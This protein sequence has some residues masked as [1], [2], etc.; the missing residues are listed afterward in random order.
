M[1]RSTMLAASLRRRCIAR[2]FSKGPIRRRKPD[3]ESALL[4]S[5]VLQ[6][7]AWP[8]EDNTAQGWMIEPFNPSSDHIKR[9]SMSPWVPCP[10]PVAR[11]MLELAKA[12]PDDIHVDLGSGDGRVNFQAMDAPFGVKRSIGID[13]DPEI[14]QKARDRL[15]KRFPVPDM[16]FYIADLKDFKNIAWDH[17]KDATIITMYFVE[18]A[19]E[20]IRPT[21]ERVLK[22]RM[23]TVVTCGYP[24]TKWDPSH[25][26]Y[27]LG[28]PVHVYKIGYPKE[29]VDLSPFKGMSEA[30]VEKIM[31]DHRKS[32]EE[33]RLIHKEE[34]DLMPAQNPN[35]N[36]EMQPEFP[37]KNYEEFMQE[38]TK[39]DFDSEERRELYIKGSRLPPEQYKRKKDH[40]DS[41]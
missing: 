22:D 29:E 9:A 1:M 2:A 21:L 11:K 14:V 20:D 31:A 17:V 24:M 15:A 16:D 35:E 23:A 4:N 30:E 38:Y 37:W 39:D 33:S 12:G 40:E 3:H 8:D 13:I 18:K 41:D 19:L 5:S 26:E 7:G 32:V 28:L 34:S 6:N 10:D 25:V 36:L 27:L